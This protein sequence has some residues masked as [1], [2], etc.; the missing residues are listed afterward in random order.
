[1]IE[2][3]VVMYWFGADLYYANVTLFVEQVRELVRTRLPK[4]S[5]L[6]WMSAP[7]RRWIFLR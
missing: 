5:G 4:S 3:G 1:M 6:W 7:S 2:P